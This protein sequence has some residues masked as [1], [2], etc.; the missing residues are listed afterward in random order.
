MEPPSPLPP[1][2]FCAP[3]TLGPAAKC[4]TALQHAGTH[5]TLWLC[6]PVPL[7]QPQKTLSR[8]PEPPASPH[9]LSWPC[10][11]HTFP[12]P[13]TS[14]MAL[15]QGRHA[16]CPL[17]CPMV[18]EVVTTPGPLH[19][20]PTLPTMSPPPQSPSWKPRNWLPLHVLL[21]CCCD[22]NTSLLLDEGFLGCSHITPSREGLA[23]IKRKK[24]QAGNICIDGEDWVT[25]PGGGVGVGSQCPHHTHTT[26]QPS[27]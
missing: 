1:H 6:C 21:S 8:S 26:S 22:T 16:L 3:H 18:L 19:S 7:P 25:L 4:S 14:Y 9:E 23:R 2:A 11:A 20:G 27:L 24:S 15:P 17:D 10:S 12:P 5:Q 13:G